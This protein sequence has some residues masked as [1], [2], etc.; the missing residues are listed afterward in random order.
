MAKDSK[1]TAS[2]PAGRW[3]APATGGYSA[4]STSGDVVSRPEKVPENGASVSR[5][6]SE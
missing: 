1:N 2:A 4:K 5:K 6:T 3:V